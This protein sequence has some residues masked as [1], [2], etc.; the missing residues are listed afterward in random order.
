[1]PRLGEFGIRMGFFLSKSAIRHHARKDR[2]MDEAKTD[3]V[4]SGLRVSISLRTDCLVFRFE[5]SRGRC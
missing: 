2:T 5:W 3:V 4:S 1:V